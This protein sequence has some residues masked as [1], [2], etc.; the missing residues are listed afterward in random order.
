MAARA[1]C[2][3]SGWRAH[4]FRQRRALAA[5]AT[6]ARVGGGAAAAARAECRAKEMVWCQKA[7]NRR[8]SLPSVSDVGA[9]AVSG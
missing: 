5:F 4:A 8:E 9:I 2:G 6:A 7:E 1:H 3:V